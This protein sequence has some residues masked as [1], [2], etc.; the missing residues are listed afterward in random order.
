MALEVAGSIPVAH[1]F[2]TL[3]T[4][5]TPS[6]CEAKVTALA[7]RREMWKRRLRFLSE[8]LPQSVEPPG[9]IVKD[10]RSPQL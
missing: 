10:G 1:P 4:R 9:W 6:E 3:S 8:G 7:A 5:L 2:R